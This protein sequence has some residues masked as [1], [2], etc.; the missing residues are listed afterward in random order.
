MKKDIFA[1][2]TPES[3]GV[4]SDAV[5]WLLDQLESGFTEPN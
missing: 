3:A 2:G 4:P 1:T 5:E